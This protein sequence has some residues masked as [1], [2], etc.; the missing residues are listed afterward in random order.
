MNVGEQLEI[1]FSG[2]RLDDGK[3]AKTCYSLCKEF[4]WDYHTLMSQPIPFVLEMI[5]QIN[6]SRKEEE[7]RSKGK[8]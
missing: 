3:F 6:E 4:G 8:K 5:T 2:G 1:H 7:K